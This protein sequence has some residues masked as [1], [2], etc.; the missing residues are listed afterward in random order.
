[1][2]FA[3]NYYSELRIIFPL[4]LD[5]VYDGVIHR[6]QQGD[7]STKMSAIVV[8]KINNNYINGN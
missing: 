2:I 4:S 3:P 8:A 6:R 5:I 1:M 7:N